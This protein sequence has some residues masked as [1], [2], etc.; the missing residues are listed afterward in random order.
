M[1]I[2][3]YRERERGHWAAAE[4]ERGGDEEAVEALTYIARRNGRT[5][6]LTVDNLLVFG[7]AKGRS[8]RK[9]L[10]WTFKN[11]FAHFSL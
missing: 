9:S 4:G 8:D 7:R 1:F 6:S 3:I 11:S 10:W 2:Q 5:I